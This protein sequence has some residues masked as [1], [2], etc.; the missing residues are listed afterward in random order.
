VLVGMLRVVHG[1]LRGW[2]LALHYT[3][4]CP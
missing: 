2:F 4:F 1:G 3:T